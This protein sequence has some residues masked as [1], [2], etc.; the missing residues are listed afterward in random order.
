MRAG[1]IVSLIIG[2]LMVIVALALVVP[3]G[4]L[5]GIYGT[6]RDSDG[7]F[8]TSTRSLTTNGYALATP[9][10]DLNLGH[11]ADWLPTGSRAALRVQATSNSDAPL[12]VGIGPTNEVS[13]YLAGVDYD[14]VTDFG[15][16][17]SS[18]KYRHLAG[19]AP[20]LPPGTQSFWVGKED[21]TGPLTLDWDIQD[22]NWTAVIMNADLSAAVNADVKLGARFDLLFPIGLGMVIGGVVLL[23]VGIL[24]IVLGARRPPTPPYVAGQAPYPPGAQYP[25]AGG[26]YPP[27]NQPLQS[28]PPQ[29]Q[30]SQEGPPTQN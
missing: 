30:P 16:G 8:M 27:Q 23:G 12:F 10:V 3:G 22:G 19:E 4:V 25:P 13:R 6:Q 1:K 11:V 15:W 21:G 18:V 5:L 17:W 14:E 26:Q 29:G 2:I 28:Q 9:D 20:T 24:L 7:F